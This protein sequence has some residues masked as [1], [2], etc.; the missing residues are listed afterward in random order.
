MNLPW[1]Q[2][3]TKKS[4]TQCASKASTLQELLGELWILFGGNKPSFELTLMS[5]QAREVIGNVA[6]RGWEDYRSICEQMLATLRQLWTQAKSLIM[7][8][9]DACEDGCMELMVESNC[10]LAACDH[11]VESKE[12]ILELNNLSAQTYVSAHEKCDLVWQKYF[13][14]KS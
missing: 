14:N 8:V 11:L 1:I 2:E 6:E 3:N 7:A 13:H 5:N 9:A 10:L 4:V 12:E